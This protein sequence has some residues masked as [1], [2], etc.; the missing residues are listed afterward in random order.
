VTAPEATILTNPG[1]G[2]VVEATNRSSVPVSRGLDIQ[3]GLLKL[4]GWG[5]GWSHRLNL[6]REELLGSLQGCY[7]FSLVISDNV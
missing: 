7:S 4:P 2:G 5:R 1:H 3:V 6:R